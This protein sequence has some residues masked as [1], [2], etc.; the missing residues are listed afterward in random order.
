MD[1]KHAGAGTP[2][3]RAG[4]RFARIEEIYYQALERPEE[5]RPAFLTM[6][7]TGEDDLRRDVEKLLS[8]D[9]E[10]GS[11]METPALDAAA[12]ALASNAEPGEQIDFVGQTILHYRVLEK[13]GEG[14]M[15]EVFVA[16]DASLNRKVALKFLPDKM[17]K[18]PAARKR[19]MRGARAAAALDNPHI[20]RIYGV[21]ESEGK[22][23]IVMEYIDGQTLR[24][25]LLRAR[26]PLNEVL[27]IAV[28]VADAVQ[29]AHGKG[30]IHRD[31]KPSN[32]MIMKTGQAKV[33][34]FGL[35]KQIIL[36][37]GIESQDESVST[38][39]RTGMTLGTLA[40]MSPEQLRGEMVD[41][42]SDIFSFGV[43][44]YEML[45]GTH[46]FKKET[47]I[48]TGS[49]IL[50]D[51]PQPLAEFRPDAPGLLP[52]VVAKM[53][54]KDPDDRYSS[55]DEVRTKLEECSHPGSFPQEAA[56]PHAGSD[57]PPSII[58]LPFDD[59]SP[60]HDNEY[61]ADG[62]TEEIIGKLSQVRGLKVIS[63]TSAMT[64]KGVRKALRAIAEEVNVRYVLEGSVRRA[65]NSLRISAQLI[66]AASDTHLWADQFRGTL[67]NIFDIQEK[68]SRAI[69]DGLKLN[70]T[71]AEERKIVRR[72]IM[73]VQ[74]YDAYLR[75]R[76]VIMQ[77]TGGHE[78]D[79]ALQALQNGLR[80]AGDNAL[81]YAGLGYVHFLYAYLGLQPEEALRT[82]EASAQRALRLD[83]EAAQAH[84]V[85]GLIAQALRGDQKEAVRHYRRALSIVPNDWDANLWLLVT[86]CYVGNNA[87]ACP[88]ADRLAEIDPL[89]PWTPKARATVLGF[90]Q[91]RFNSSLAFLERSLTL[92]DD[93]SARHCLA[94]ALACVG[95]FKDAVAALEPI[96]LS[97]GND[98]LVQLCR[99]LRLALQGEKE[100]MPELLSPEF[101]AAARRSAIWSYYAA[102][103]YAIVGDWEQTLEWLENAVNR[104]FINYPF[105][106][107]Y[108]PFLARLR[109]NSRFRRLMA[110]VKGE[111][112]RFEP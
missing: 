16:K 62:L 7:C 20:C 74:A 105:L 50:K 77:F 33:T 103:V 93:H 52:W 12:R 4:D 32:I 100:K 57:Q 38:I 60:G 51:E 107:E 85:L 14:G 34:D 73:D 21:G 6:A 48:E 24:E 18:D 58:V 82:A 63:R 70:L 39:T 45:T 1:D 111:W 29:A 101:V 64:F 65:G 79:E 26:L 67:D 110:R 47:G 5:E 54:A 72:P 92:R 97:A 37:G 28:E 83:S 42:R 11:F 49:A 10:A 43:V 23:F 31:L 90:C 13:I 84:I 2:R 81:L 66:D 55:I 61:F 102:N 106:C 36:P 69:A 25:K 15:G 86:Y 27:Q 56:V 112:K 71:P 59:V 40:Y 19:F 87:A 41:A 95:R 89:N 30:I 75:A 88:L 44:L 53:L 9:K 99:L 35:A 96:G 91:G 22:D 98:A 104:G 8:L 68:V 3:Y 76:N 109:S 108:D 80:L 46:P 94:F 78:L 17:Q